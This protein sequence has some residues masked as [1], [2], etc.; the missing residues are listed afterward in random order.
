MR[1]QLNELPSTSALTGAELARLRR[2]RTILLSLQQLVG[3]DELGALVEQTQ[4]GM[5]TLPELELAGSLRAG[6][7]PLSETD[8]IVAERLLGGEGQDPAARLG[9]QSDPT[10]EALRREAE[11]QLA[12]WQQLVGYPA[13]TR[14]VRDAAEVLVRICEDLLNGPGDG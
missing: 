11:R 9:I 13:S 12:H 3:S 10:P 7:I 5:H 1:A 2:Q 4:L 6:T 8:R 14:A